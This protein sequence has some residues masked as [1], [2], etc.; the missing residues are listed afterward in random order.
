MDLFSCKLRLGG[1]LANEV[2]KDNV[3]APEIQVLR[4]AHGGDAVVG[5]ERTGEAADYDVVGERARLTALYGEGPVI[6]AFGEGAF[7]PLPTTLPGFEVPK[8]APEVEV[9]TGRRRK[10][11]EEP[12]V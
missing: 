9:P 8:P 5:I 11:V 4:M 6:K 10:P 1:S 7:V 3:T 2:P 12:L